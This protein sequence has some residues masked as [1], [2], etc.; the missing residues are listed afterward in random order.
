M[1]V[2]IAI[3]LLYWRLVEKRKLSEIGAARSI[4]GW[5]I[6]AGLGILLL[7]VSVCA[8]MVTGTIKPSGFSTD[9][10]ITMLL[11]ML[12]GYTTQGA[13]EEL[14]AEGLYSAHSKTG[15]P[16]LWL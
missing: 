6:G 15:S 14:L 2:L 11:L 1:A 5:F 10:S 7:I 16:C 12:G 13:A 3:S 8:V 4:G 9:L